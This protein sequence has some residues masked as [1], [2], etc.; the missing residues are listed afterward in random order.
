[1]RFLLLYIVCFSIVAGAS[2]QQLGTTNLYMQGY[3]SAGILDASE[4]ID[5]VSISAVMEYYVQP[6]PNISALYNYTSSATANLNAIYDWTITP[7][8]S[9]VITKP[10]SVGFAGN[11]ITVAFPAAA[12]DYLLNVKE[13]ASIS[14]C[15]DLVGT[16]IQVRTIGRPNVSFLTANEGYDVCLNGTNGSLNELLPT[17]IDV[18]F[19]SNVSGNR[20]M[21][22]RYTITGAITG[23][24]I[25]NKT[26]DIVETGA[27]TGYFAVDEEFDFYDHY[28][29]SITRVDDRITLKSGVTTSATGN[30]SFRVG[31]LKIPETQSI[32]H[33]KNVN[34]Y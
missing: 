6:D 20:N 24:L 21:K 9:V 16:D 23:V 4:N 3:N 33:I 18:I 13:T 34:S 26:V 28:T 1:M 17:P 15:E 7:S 32:K 27:G 29:I 2:S 31:I 22:L 30:I 25:A 8:A 19:T 14:S 5:S 12:A 11:F 10:K